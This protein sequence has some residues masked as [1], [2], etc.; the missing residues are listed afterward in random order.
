MASPGLIARM[1]KTKLIQ[2]LMDL[3][4]A[5]VCLLLLMVLT[6]WGTIY[7]KGYGLWAAQERFFYSWVVDGSIPFPGGRL[8][9]WV[10]FV[11][12]LTA[13]VFR[14]IYRWR[15]AG[16]IL[17]HWGLLV[18]LVGSFVTYHHAIESNV[19]LLEGEATNVS[20]DYRQWE[21]SIWPYVAGAGEWQVT[22]IDAGLLRAEQAVTLEKPA[23]VVTTLDY[24]PNSSP[25][26]DGTLKRPAEQAGGIAGLYQA[27][28][29]QDPQRDVPGGL[30]RLVSGDAQATVLLYGGLVN[31]QLV[32]LNDETYA[33]QL[34]RK[35]YSLPFTIS[36]T[37]FVKE[38]HPG[39]S[40]PSSYE[41][42]VRVTYGGV[43]RPV[44]IFMNNPLRHHNFTFY[45]ASFAET[46]DGEQSVFAVVENAGRLIP[47]ISSG[48]VFFGMSVHFLVMLAQRRETR[49]QRKM[50]A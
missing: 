38:E 30:F 10:L 11:N 9:L 13:T 49:I 50:A 24:F 44:R 20:Q 4:V 7:Q 15:N 8:L 21:L 18:L 35:R 31:P 28:T 27:D 42:T 41:S 12:L 26:P 22:A 37:D 16:L 23:V 6:A 32:T 33:V 19:P 14:L 46:E 39:T 45:Q 5:V 36:L 25:N 40:M 47:Y 1:R 2:R 48:I 43:D 34:R 3:R 17:I 29:N